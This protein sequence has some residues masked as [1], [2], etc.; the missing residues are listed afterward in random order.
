[1]N[2][3]FFKLIAA[4][5]IITIVT[6][7]VMGLATNEASFLLIT[8][9]SC[10][11]YFYS[12]YAFTTIKTKWVNYFG[13]CM[14]GIIFWFICFSLSPDSTDYKRNIEAGNWL[15]YKLFVAVG[16]SLN[17]IDF[18]NEPYNL[19]IELVELLFI[20]VIIS[21]L[22]FLGGKVKFYKIRQMN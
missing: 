17:F 19:N 6:I 16:S 2:G 5:I 3:I 20:P 21:T 12:G 4:H 22:Q 18:M 1:M 7:L 10:M 15:Y 8:T 14:I 9:F 11:L 13:I